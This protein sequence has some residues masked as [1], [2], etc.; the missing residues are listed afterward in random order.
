MGIGVFARWLQILRYNFK[1]LEPASFY[2][3]NDTFRYFNKFVQ[4]VFVVITF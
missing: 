2:N 4:S 1:S 3:N